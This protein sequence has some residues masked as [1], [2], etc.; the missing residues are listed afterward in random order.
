[1]PVIDNNPIKFAPLPTI[2]AIY[3]SELN[4]VFYIPFTGEIFANYED[5]LARISLYRQRVWTCALT[6]KQK[7]TYREALDS[8]RKAT[9]S[10]DFNLP[11]VW[12]KPTL[13]LIHFN[14][15]PIGELVDYIYD[16][17][18]GTRFVDEMVFIDVPTSGSERSVERAY[19]KEKVP[20]TTPI[21]L[22]KKLHDK[23]QLQRELRELKEDNSQVPEDNNHYRIQLVNFPTKEYIVA[24]NQ[25]RRGRQSLSKQT[26][27]KYIKE[28]ASKDRWLNAPWIVKPALVA[29]FGL[30]TEMP[31]N[32]KELLERKKEDDA[33]SRRGKPKRPID[34][35]VTPV[36]DTELLTVPEYARKMEGDAPLPERPLPT[37]QLYNIPNNKIMDTLRIYAF[38]SLYSKPLLLYPFK[39]NDFIAGL[40]S[41]TAFDPFAD[42]LCE[43]FGSLLNI[44][45]A[46]FQHKFDYSHGGNG[47]HPYMIGLPKLPKNTT[48]EELAYK[49]QEIQYLEPILASYHAF[50]KND[51]AAVD[52]WYKWRPGQ[53]GMPIKKQK[54]LKS[55]GTFVNT[56]AEYL[57]AWYVAL[58]GLVKD[59]Y[60]SSD[61]D[62]FL[63]YRVLFKLLKLGHTENG[64]KE[65][66]GVKV[67]DKPMEVDESVQEEQEEN[68]S[69]QTL[70]E[71]PSSVFE[72]E[73]LEDSIAS[74]RE[75]RKTVDLSDDDETWEE[76]VLPVSSRSSTRT[77]KSVSH[78]QQT[79]PK[80]TPKKQK[81]KATKSKKIDTDTGMG[82]VELC[83]TME[84]GFWSI[85]VEDRIDLL[86]FFIEE[87]LIDCELL[88]TF[89]DNSIEQT[90]EMKKELRELARH[91]KQIAH[92]IS[93][94]EKVNGTGVQHHTPE[95]DEE[96]SNHN[97]D[98]ESDF[99][100]KPVRQRRTS[101]RITNVRKDY[102]GLDGSEPPQ[103]TVIQ[104]EREEL[105]ER[106]RIITRRED[107]LDYEIRAS[108]ATCR[109]RCIGKDR[110]GN[111][112]WWFDG[113]FGYLSI[114]AV[115]KHVELS[116]LQIPELT[117]KPDPVI[118]LDYG[119]G[120]LFVEE[121]YDAERDSQN[122]FDPK[123][124]LRKGVIDGKWG[125]YST[126]EEID[127]LLLWCDQRGINEKA[128]KYNLIAQQEFI[129]DG[130]NKRLEVF[131]FCKC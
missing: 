74:R 69:H 45:C 8:E 59:W 86:T 91:R 27:R 15:L 58:F 99:E 36:E 70:E 107:I 123:S 11:S 97:T 109:I 52:Q 4:Q 129:L 56:S 10:N 75:K 105:E 39:F 128:L 41:K 117:F 49:P 53:W 3:N 12:I 113:S 14:C 55:A 106:D 90:T 21:T 114:E 102:E 61:E 50:D 28:V 96:Q 37:F 30:R 126:K 19:I 54:K 18:R 127:K 87:C 104:S 20:N 81:V 119:L 131:F 84:E 68:A 2:E 130:M 78:I 1:M 32:V 120:Y 44:A 64:V 108:E 122:L 34:L 16:Y 46:E 94:I 66:N 80:P 101:S 125:F 24:P 79:T 17:F 63:R 73:A 22:E 85:S 6:Q 77:S 115:T 110:F 118:P 111:R 103:T 9:Q 89:R 42:L 33:G 25:M 35:Y 51:R 26:F 47:V 57:K 83:N 98:N 38:L 62:S 121:I 92:S 43:V 124:D 5:Y 65:E 29:K 31:T 72:D 88:R 13:E 82:F 40:E 95:L 116:S 7:L 71:Q 93:E 60:F 48:L 112:Y 67:E 76:E 100:M 23:R